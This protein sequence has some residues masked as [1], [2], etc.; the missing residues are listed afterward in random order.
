MDDNQLMARLAAG[1][2]AALEELILRHRGAALQQAR[3]I[4]KDHALAEDMVQEAFARVYLLRHKYRPDFA[5]TTY[6]RVLVR[7]LCI[8]QL[9]RRKMPDDVSPPAPAD[10]AE[11]AYWQKERRSRLWNELRALDQTDQALLTGYALEGRSYRELAQA[12][13]LS[14]PTVKIR[15]HRIRKRLRDKEC[16][17]P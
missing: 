6:L 16:D 2:T 8:D 1:E 17:D 3:S 11:A 14:L 12:T 4:L 7:N 13:G 15:L 9:R 10:S 5:F